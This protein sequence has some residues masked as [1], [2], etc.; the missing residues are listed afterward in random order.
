[1]HAAVQGLRHLRRR[2]TAADVQGT[3]RRLQHRGVFRAWHV[4]F[5]LQAAKGG[6]LAVQHHDVGQCQTRTAEIEVLQHQQAWARCCNLPDQRDQFR[7][8]GCWRYL[9]QHGWSAQLARHRCQRDAFLLLRAAATNDHRYPARCPLQK[10]GGYKAF[11]AQ[12]QTAGFCGYRK[13]QHPGNASRD[14]RVRRAPDAQ[15]IDGA[16]FQKGRIHAWHDAERKSGGWP[17]VLHRGKTYLGTPY[18][19]VWGNHNTICGNSVMASNNSSNMTRKGQP[20]FIISPIGIPVSAL[21][22]NRSMPKGG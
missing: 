10:V 15:G 18:P 12:A 16:V 19:M 21:V 11:F 13:H 14:H 2:P 1:M 7:P 9:A 6:N 8:A 20:S 4:Y 22:T 3:L 17:G 5:D